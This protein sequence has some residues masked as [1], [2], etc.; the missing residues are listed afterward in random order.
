[1][2]KPNSTL[3]VIERALLARLIQTHGICGVL[4]EIALLAPND[5]IRKAILSFCKELNGNINERSKQRQSRADTPV[6]QRLDKSVELTGST[7]DSVSNIA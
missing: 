1:M 3:S 6:L 4:D 7:V 5:D 2:N